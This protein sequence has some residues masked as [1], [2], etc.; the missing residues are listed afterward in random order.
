MGNSCNIFKSICL[1]LLLTLAGGLSGCATSYAPKDESGG[2][3]EKQL[4]ED[5]YEIYFYGNQHT[6]V[7]KVWYYWLYRC[8]ELTLEKGYHYFIYDPPKPAARMQSKE[9]GK[10]ITFTSFSDYSNKTGKH[11][12]YWSMGVVTLYKNPLP[13]SAWFVLDAV[14]VKEALSPY[15]ES[16]GHSTPPDR[17]A[18]LIDA[19]VKAAVRSHRVHGREAELLRRELE[20]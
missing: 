19:K 13:G 2:Y 20:N 7:Q 16:N 12:R 5:R 14:T 8:A 10:H 9:G 4:A 18:L 3:T 1:L 15:I 6:S 17:R 11:S